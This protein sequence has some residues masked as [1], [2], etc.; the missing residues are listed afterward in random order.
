MLPAGCKPVGR[1]VEARGRVRFPLPSSR[2]LFRKESGPVITEETTVLE[3]V[4]KYPEARRVFGAYNLRYGTC[5]TCGSLFYTVEELATSW[6][7]PPEDLLADLRRAAAS[8][9]RPDRR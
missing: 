6:G 5:I 1:A 4:R 3:V 7:I 8:R 2:I 9:G